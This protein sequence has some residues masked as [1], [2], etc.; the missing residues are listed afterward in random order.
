MTSWPFEIKKILSEI[1]NLEL[2]LKN[3]INII[4]IYK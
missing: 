3:E 1:N 4:I 2:R